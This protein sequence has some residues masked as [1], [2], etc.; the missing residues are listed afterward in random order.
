VYV[1]DAGW[2]VLRIVDKTTV[3]VEGRAVESD[4]LGGYTVHVGRVQVDVVHPKGTMAGNERAAVM[5]PAKE[6]RKIK[7]GDKILAGEKL[8]RVGTRLIKVSD[9]GFSSEVF[10][11]QRERKK[12]AKR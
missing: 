3:Y 5:L 11:Y 8:N 12:G 9:K 6:L 7:V 4:V 2:K 1:Q 10:V